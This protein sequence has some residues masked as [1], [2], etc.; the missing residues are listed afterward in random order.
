V[1][2]TA[3]ASGV[4]ANA[5]EEGGGRHRRSRLGAVIVVVAKNLIPVDLKLLLKMYRALFT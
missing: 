5:S 3:S 4:T 2:T 1:V